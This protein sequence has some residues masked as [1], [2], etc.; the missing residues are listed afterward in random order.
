MKKNTWVQQRTD[1]AATAEDS[2]SLLSRFPEQGITKEMHMNNIVYIVGFIV[3][4]A[5]VLSFLGF[6]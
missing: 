6:R 5:F 4:V 2:Q 3:I 1:I